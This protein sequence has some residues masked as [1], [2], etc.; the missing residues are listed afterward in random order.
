MHPISSTG[1]SSGLELD[2]D[3]LEVVQPPPFLAWLYPDVAAARPIAVA[4]DELAASALVAN[5]ITAHLL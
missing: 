5:E 1:S 3:K 2:G 4:V